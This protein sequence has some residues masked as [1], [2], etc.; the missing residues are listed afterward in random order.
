[1]ALDFETGQESWRIFRIMAEFVE[2]FEVMSPLDK[3]VSIFGSART[4]PGDKYYQECE[5]TARLLAEAGFTIITGGGPGIMEAGNKGAYDAGGRSVGLNIVLPHE[6]VSNKYQTISMDFHYFYAR[7]VMFTKYAAAFVCFPG[8]FGTMDEL[9]ETLTLIQTHKV[10]PLPV[11]LY[12]SKYWSGLI[13]WLKS[14]L[15]PE[16]ID[17]GDTDIFKLVDSPQEVLKLVKQGVKKPWWGQPIRPAIK[18]N[19][20][21]AGSARLSASPRSP[22]RRNDQADDGPIRRVSRFGSRRKRQ[23]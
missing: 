5:E 19:G 9:F 8:G 14:A 15:A 23:K 18:S 4:R 3:A 22:V 1:M 11:I 6:Q 21:A 16:Y 7:K 13:Q 2:G 17:A 12:G 20:K 10:N